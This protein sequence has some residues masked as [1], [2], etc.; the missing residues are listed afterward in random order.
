MKL[1][2]LDFIDSKYAAQRML[3]SRYGQTIDFDRLTPTKA[4]EMHSRVQNMLEAQQNTSTGFVRENNSE[5]MKLVLINKILESTIE[6]DDTLPVDMKDPKVRGVMDKIKRNQNLSPDEQKMANKLAAM[7]AEGKDQDRKPPF[8][9]DESSIDTDKYGNKIKKKNVP[10]H[11]A[12]KGMRKSMQ[13]QDINEGT[14]IQTAQ[15]VLAAKDMGD[16]LQ[17]MLQDVSEMQFKDLPAVVE[18]AKSEVGTEQAD[19]FSQAATKALQDLLMAT[20]QAKQ[21]MDQAMGALT[22]EGMSV[23]TDSAEVDT[24]IDAI[25]DTDDDFAVDIETNTDEM[26]EIDVDT[27]DDAASVGRAER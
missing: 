3:E 13:T 10:K 19:Q 17:K 24:D 15:V 18:S 2:E 14:E 11:L 22:G 20:Q 23:P 25:S 12:K 21:E 1:N 7:Q 9:P 5:Y 8:E 27:D 16:R 26:P 4:R 6:E